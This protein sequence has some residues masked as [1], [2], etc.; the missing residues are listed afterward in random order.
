MVI[1]K[2][3][4]EWCQAIGLDSIHP[5]APLRTCTDNSRRLHEL[6]VLDNGGTCNRQRPLELPSAARYACNALKN[7][8]PDGMPEQPEQAQNAPKLRGVGMGLRHKNEVSRSAN[9]FDNTN[10]LCSTRSAHFD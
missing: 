2:P 9:T 3:L 8:D 6:Q 1:G 5:P 4:Y 10:L 7:N